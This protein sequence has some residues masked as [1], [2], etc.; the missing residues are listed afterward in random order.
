M[1]YCVQLI[2]SCTCNTT[3]NLFSHINPILRCHFYSYNNRMMIWI[4][5]MT[6]RSSLLCDHARLPYPSDVCH[7]QIKHFPT[8]NYAASEIFRVGVHLRTHAHTL[9][10]SRMIWHR[11][12]F[13]QLH[14][15]FVNF[16]SCWWLTNVSLPPA[17]IFYAEEWPGVQNFLGERAWPTD[18]IAQ[19]LGPQ[20]ILRS[21]F[22][23]HE[24]SVDPT[25]RQKK[26]N[27]RWKT[28]TL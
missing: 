5:S 18:P 1:L 10:H 26:V 7:D 3:F 21:I 12:K 28:M 11:L 27:N 9:T 6:S 16:L 23:S 2:C 24:T 4:Y 17:H 8:M 19:A 14:K 20:T 25:S 22:T 15:G 13:H